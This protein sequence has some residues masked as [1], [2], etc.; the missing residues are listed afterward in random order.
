MNTKNINLIRVYLCSSV[1]KVFFVSFVTSVAKISSMF[2]FDI[3]S[4]RVKFLLHF[5]VLSV[6]SVVKCFPKL[7]RP[8]QSLVCASIRFLTSHVRD[9]IVLP[10]HYGPTPSAPRV[11]DS[12]S[13]LCT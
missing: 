11:D 7:V 1:A 2:S 12:S 5:S 6:H 9:A 8:I 4:F 3:S 10:P 13:S